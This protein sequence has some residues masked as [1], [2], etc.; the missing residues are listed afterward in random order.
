MPCYHGVILDCDF[1]VHKR[2]TKIYRINRKSG[3]ADL[4]LDKGSLKSSIEAENQRHRK[5]LHD[6]V[7]LYKSRE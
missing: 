4:V 5:A 2:L 6:I 3:E 1:F 7:K